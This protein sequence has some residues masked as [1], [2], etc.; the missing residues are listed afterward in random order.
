MNSNEMTLYVLGTSY[1]VC[2]R[3]YD[4]L[5][6]FK[7]QSI[8]GYCDDVK[9]IICICNLKTHPG[10]EDE[11]EE[12][13]LKVEKLVLRHEIIHAFLSESGLQTSTLQ[14]DGGWA[15]NEE[16]VDWI[17]LQFPKIL[18]AIQTVEAL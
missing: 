16:M 18:K 8:D 9:K 14:M 5:S 17:A 7:K 11:T 13:C 10:Y 2:R 12:Y 3:N 4:E 1:K 15:K 6:L